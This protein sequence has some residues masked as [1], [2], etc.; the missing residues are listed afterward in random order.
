M[1]ASPEKRSAAMKSRADSGVHRFLPA[2][3]RD[4]AA[5][6]RLGSLRLGCYLFGDAVGAAAGGRVVFRFTAKSCACRDRS[7]DSPR[8]L[9]AGAD[10]TT[11]RGS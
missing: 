7:I 1:T 5:R 2:S 8:I 6:R 11:Q 4:G 9:A 10:A 3:A